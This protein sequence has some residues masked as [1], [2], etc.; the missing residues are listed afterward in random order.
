MSTDLASLL[1]GCAG[2]DDACVRAKEYVRAIV[3]PALVGDKIASQN[4]IAALAELGAALDG[5]SAS[6]AMDVEIVRGLL[7]GLLL[8]NF[9]SRCKAFF[10]HVRRALAQVTLADEALFFACVTEAFATTQPG[11]AKQQQ[12][13]T[14]LLQVVDVQLAGVQ[15][16]LHVRTPA[17]DAYLKL[18][19][20]EWF[21]ALDSILAR[22][23]AYAGGAQSVFTLDQVRVTVKVVV[24]TVS[25]SKSLRASA[26]AFVAE[27]G[28]VVAP[29][30][31]K[32]SSILSCPAAA[33]EGCPLA[34]D[35]LAFAGMGLVA[36]T[37]CGQTNPEARVAT[38]IELLL[39][40]SASSDEGKET[41][42][43]TPSKC[44]MARVA[45]FSSTF[46]VVDEQL[47]VA[48]GLLGTVFRNLFSLA[49]DTTEVTL[50]T[51][52]LTALE[53]W[54]IKAVR[55]HA[56]DPAQRAVISQCIDDM[57]PVMLQNFAHSFRQ[58]VN[59]CRSTF[60]RL[61]SLPTSVTGSKDDWVQRVTPYFAASEY[62]RAAYT[63]MEL[64]LPH[65]TLAQV[66]SL[67]PGIFSHLLLT[68]NNRAI[69]TKSSRVLVAYLQVGIRD[70][71]ALA[72]KN[73]SKVRA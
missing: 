6:G 51:S 32:L 8:V 71:R 65:L 7:T 33:V 72:K 30:V 44:A 41:A 42:V 29:I 24:E 16:L 57:W 58:V 48:S 50:K 25:L 64:V 17:T 28:P 40:E 67:R 21:A 45:I 4:T 9:D 20:A 15:G 26:A 68:F 59:V 31:E 34:K 10:K 1:Q 53:T 38:L 46:I 73:K 37:L 3:E 12:D 61:I 55:V 23:L 13:S 19:F 52:A 60:K 69:W 43:S 14:G 66:D 54:L 39:Q 5:K 2:A 63:V 49:R 18:H 36:I 70:Q 27:N 56:L 62:S 11:D 22:L 35:I 47:L